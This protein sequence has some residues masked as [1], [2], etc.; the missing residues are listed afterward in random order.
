MSIVV[1]IKE[2]RAIMHHLMQTIGMTLFPFVKPDAACAVS[3]H[4][5]KIAEDPKNW[6]LQV[7]FDTSG[8]KTKITFEWSKQ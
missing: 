3:D 1:G 7:S 4:M 2:R 8:G 5:Q 6:N